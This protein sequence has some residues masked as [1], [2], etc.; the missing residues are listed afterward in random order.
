VKKIVLLLMIFLV[1]CNQ[2]DPIIDPLLFE[3]REQVEVLENESGRIKYYCGTDTSFF[4]LETDDPELSNLIIDDIG[5]FSDFFSIYWMGNLQTILN[6]PCFIVGESDIQDPE[7]VVEISG[8]IRASLPEDDFLVSGVVPF[9]SK[10]LIKKENCP[11]S[12]EETDDTFPFHN[13]RWRA[14]EIDFLASK[15]Y[16]TCEYN[17]ILVTFTLEALED[18]YVFEYFMGDE[19]CAYS[20]EIL[21][22]QELHIQLEDCTPAP[23][24]ITS[25]MQ[26]FITQFFEVLTDPGKTSGSFEYEMNGNILLLRNQGGTIK[27]IGT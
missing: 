16:P 7:L 9:V 23:S 5:V 1:G 3:N 11:V 10:R 2:E 26:I 4:Y 25:H 8:S 15:T 24:N 22:G 19:S 18:R 17:N 27:L 14:V 20:Y 13:T 12:Y 6:N 21:A